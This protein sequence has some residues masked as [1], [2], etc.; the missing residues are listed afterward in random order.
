MM[1][2]KKIHP[3]ILV[4]IFLFCQQFCSAKR[5]YVDPSHFSSSS[6][7][8][9]SNPWRS[10]SQ[11]N[12]H[13]KSLLPGDTVF[14]KKGQSFAGTL[15]VLSSGNMNHPI[16][17]T[18]YGVGALPIFSNDVSDVIN[19]KNV[20]HVIIDGIKIIDHSI[21][22]TDHSVTAKISYA[23]N[24]DN[25]NHCTIRNCD[26]SLVGV[27]ISVS[28]GSDFTTIEGNY[29]HNLRMVRNTPVKDNPNDDYGANPV[30]VGSSNNNVISNYFE[31]CWASSFDYGFDGGAIE[32][33]GTEMNGNKIMY[34]TALNCNGF[35]EIG[36][37][38]V[39]QAVNNTIAYNKIINCGIIGYFH[40]TATYKVKVQNMQYFNNTVIE[41][42]KQFTKPAY[43]FAMPREGTQGMLV[44]KNN[45]FW[46]TS[47]VK[48][49]PVRF[50]NG[51]MIHENNLFN[52][53]NQQM[54]FSLHKTEKNLLR[55]KIFRSITGVP[56]KW[57]LRPAP[58]SS[59]VDFGSNV[60]L[61]RDFKGSMLSSRPDAGAYELEK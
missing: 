30:V 29:I 3:T 24:V 52:L 49:A 17:Y 15:M 10:I 56:I 43:L 46:L 27:G 39:G 48:F 19:L 44:V 57:D 55:E 54:E 25:A 18:H 38:D 4:I 37:D 16:V 40:N 47:G 6:I 26:I 11:V 32:M 61:A 28:Q 8:T 14:F 53:P 9:F 60:G 31:D 35:I 58:G 22:I 20:H 21:S 42:M 51:V 45:I 12:A 41:T 5:Y 1:I 36:S 50:A 33:F 23:I 7:G 13:V 59:A 2:K 34:N